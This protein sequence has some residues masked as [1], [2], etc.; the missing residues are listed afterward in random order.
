[1]LIFKDT[2]RTMKDAYAYPSKI[3]NNN[4]VLPVYS[5]NIFK[6]ACYKKCYQ[7]ENLKLRHG[8]CDKLAIDSNC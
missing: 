1:M 7:T 6:Q 2:N 5:F 8:K 3:K 4:N